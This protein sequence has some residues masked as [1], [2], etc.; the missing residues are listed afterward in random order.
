MHSSHLEATVD[1]ET[2][3]PASDICWLA[4]GAASHRKI[5]LQ[6]PVENTAVKKSRH[7]TVHAMRATPPA[8][9]NKNGGECSQTASRNLRQ[10]K[11]RDLMFCKEAGSGGD[12]SQ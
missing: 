9:D 5:L 12:R 2:T 1:K 11:V 7:G 3:K 6:K 4:S 10:Y 8:Y